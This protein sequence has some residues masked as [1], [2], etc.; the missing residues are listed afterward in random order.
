MN[1][2]G[3]VGFLVALVAL[4]GLSF[5]FARSRRSLQR[6]LAEVADR[7]DDAVDG[8]TNERLESVLAHLQDAVDTARASEQDAEGERKRLALALEATSDGVVVV[9]PNGTVVLR[10]APADRFHGARHADVLAEEAM[11]ELLAGA[12]RGEAGERELPLFGPPQQV[13]HVRA[14]PLV[15]EHAI[16]GAVAFVRD[17]SKTRRVESVRRDFVANVSHELKTPIGALGLLAE[18]IASGNDDLVVMQRLAERVVLEAD[19]LGDIVD[20]LLDLSLIEAQ[21]SPTRDPLPVP[22]LVGEAIDQVRAAADVA[23]VPVSIVGRI[24]DVELVCDRRQILSALVNLLENAIKY[25]EPDAPVEIAAALEHGRVRIM[26]RDRGIG[27]PKRDLER[28]FERFYRV[29]RA[30]GRQAGGTGLGLSI[31]RHVAQAHGGEVTVESVEGEGSTFALHLPVVQRPT[32]SIDHDGS[33]RANGSRRNS[34]M[35]EAS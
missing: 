3:W 10:N 2:L 30:R 14:L 1:V 22:L 25:S 35:S 28:I 6:Q 17:V 16:V 32:P 29:D 4:A 18:T 20:D 13:L 34:W 12:C 7:L 31:V 23:S 24:P 27:I 19:R 5:A 11:G 21:E 26:V 9:D 15:H 33:V 8:R